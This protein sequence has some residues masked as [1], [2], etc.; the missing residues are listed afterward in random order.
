M[1]VTFFLILYGTN[2][3]ILLQ[4][5]I[6]PPD[7]N[8]DICDPE[9]AARVNLRRHDTSPD[10]KCDVC[11][12][13]FVPRVNLRRHDTSTQTVMNVMMIFLLR[14]KLRRHIR[15][16]PPKPAPATFSLYS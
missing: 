10:P 13:E 3:L 1:Y 14:V 6:R 8:C 15:S 4:Y 5:N 7:P 11:A 2:F 12:P 16:G 9:F